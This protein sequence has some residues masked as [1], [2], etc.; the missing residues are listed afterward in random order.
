MACNRLGQTHLSCV[1]DAYF[2]QEMIINIYDFLIEECN[3]ATLKADGYYHSI[4]DFC[5]GGENVIY[6]LRNRF[7]NEKMDALNLL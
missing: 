7:R 5:H 3:S 1:D 4:Y 2:D 6:G